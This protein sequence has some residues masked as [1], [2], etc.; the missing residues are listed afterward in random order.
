MSRYVTS[1][2]KPLLVAWAISVESIVPAVFVTGAECVK[3]PADF[4]LS[5]TSR[6]LDSLMKSLRAGRS[7]RLWIKLDMDTPDH[8]MPIS[9]TIARRRRSPQL[10]VSTTGI[11]E[12]A[13]IQ[14]GVDLQFQQSH[15]AADTSSRNLGISTVAPVPNHDPG[16]K[17]FSDCAVMS[18]AVA[19]RRQ[20]IASRACRSANCV[21]EAVISYLVQQKV[22]ETL[23]SETVRPSLEAAELLD[24]SAPLAVAATRVR[25][26]PSGE[27]VMTPS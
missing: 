5:V 12:F 16:V 15:V 7:V 18:S 8:K 24:V 10:F 11:P 1:R 19:V 9:R 27:K 6:L 26:D 14:C 20:Q 22:P 21:S 2:V 3:W 17:E 4:G 13:W 23:V 25:V